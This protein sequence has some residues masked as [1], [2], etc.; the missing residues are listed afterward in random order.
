LEI[1]KRGSPPLQ[2]PRGGST[3]LANF[4]NKLLS[5]LFP[6]FALPAAVTAQD[7]GQL[8]GLYC[9]AC[10]ADDGKGAT[11]GVF[12][13]LAGSEWLHGEPERA[14]KIVL[15]GMR[16]PVE[17][18]GQSYNLVMP[19]QGEVL[20]DANLA[21]ILSYVRT[22][23]GHRED[24]VGAD[25]VAAVRAAAADRNEPWTAEELLEA[26]PLPEVESAL[27]N[28]TSRAYRG[29]WQKLPD[30]D[31]LEPVAEGEHEDGILRLGH[32]GR[33]DEFGLVWE[34]DF[35]AEK[36]ADYV[37]RLSADA[38]G[39]VVLN[40][41]RL[42]N[43]D[44]LGTV[45]PSRTREKRVR[46]EKGAHPIRIEYFELVGTKDII[47]SWKFD[48]EEE[49]W[50]FLS[51]SRGRRAQP[52]IPTILIEPG[53]ERA[54]IYRNFIPDTTPRAIGIGFP[55]GVNFAYSADHFAPELAWTGDFIDAGEP[56]STR[57]QGNGPPAGERVV[58]LTNFPV[59]PEGARFRGYTLD[60]VGNPTFMVTVDELVIE[61]AYR[62][63]EGKLVRT[64]TATGRGEPV[65][66]TV[67]P[68]GADSV[69]FVGN[70]REMPT[71]SGPAT[72]RLDGHAVISPGASLSLR[73][74]ART[75]SGGSGKDAPFSV[76][77]GAGDS[78][79]LTYV[80]E[81]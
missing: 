59:F 49:P 18:A 4:M 54:A 79:A 31:A 39:R 22:T 2:F 48:G 76:V 47:L 16:G 50:R 11:A 8:Y 26:H 68:P 30:F 44:G 57:G 34:G 19:P 62:A 9:A 72:M 24:K 1:E 27:K 74:D 21:A 38:A 43:I 7:G 32:A 64:L 61:D 29:K 67:A 10:H 65:A 55:G 80:W 5:L 33:E 6:A 53:P 51:E 20:S 42:M 41:E 78:A 60:A 36:T 12:P 14:I 46:L 75:V 45:N 40:G 15:H 3:V 77:L 13:P 52:V 71:D 35:V 23:W 37:F 81:D 56:W 69:E 25:Q 73:I 17:V 70:V 63:G 28:L 66:L 58:K